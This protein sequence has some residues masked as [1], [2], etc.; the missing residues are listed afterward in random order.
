MNNVNINDQAFVNSK[1][2]QE[3]LKENPSQGFLD[4]RVYTASQAI[5]INNLK[6]VVS[7]TIGNNNVI[8]YEGYSDASGV[9]PTIILPTPKLNK[10][11]LIIPNGINYDILAIY[12]PDNVSE[13]FEVQ[14]FEDVNVLQSINITLTNMGGY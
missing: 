12:V 13:K 3:F 6:V 7:K 5:P 4:I 1:E 8:F 9:V 11:D 10:D 14:M 2:Y